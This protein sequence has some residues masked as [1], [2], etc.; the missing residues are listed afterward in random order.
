[1]NSKGKILHPDITKLLLLAVLIPL[2]TTAAERLFSLM[3]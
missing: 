1:M 3:K 2:L